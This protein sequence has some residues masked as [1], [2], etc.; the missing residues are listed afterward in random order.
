MNLIEEA[1]Q[2]PAAWRSKILGTTAGA[3]FKIIRMDENGIP[4]ESHPDF[5]EALLV[6]DG[7]MALDVEGAVTVMR[8]GDF[9]V[10][11]AGKTHSVLKGSHGTLFLVDAER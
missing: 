6:I 10:V 7:E 9:F 1:A 2:L 4:P 3:N 8:S 11:P 5:D